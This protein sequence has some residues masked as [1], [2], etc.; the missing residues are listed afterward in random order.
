MRKPIFIV[1]V[2][3]YFSEGEIDGIKE[4]LKHIGEDYHVLVVTGNVED[5][6]FKMFSDHEIEPIEL[7]KL[8]EL[9]NAK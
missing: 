4:G 6:E 9:I 7:E 1:T 5:P 8:K 3:S 2:P